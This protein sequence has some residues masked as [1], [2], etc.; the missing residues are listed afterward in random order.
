MLRTKFK[1]VLICSIVALMFSILLYVGCFILQSLS[2]LFFIYIPG[3][4]GFI[5]GF[6]TSILVHPRRWIWLPGL[7]PAVSVNIGYQVGLLFYNWFS[8]EEVYLH[9]KMLVLILW[10][11]IPI[12]LASIVGAFL[13][14]LLAHIWHKK[15]KA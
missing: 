8:H 2:T 10:S 7:L 14:Q 11:G 12:L 3:F 15:Q 1:T 13:G 4:I 5:G 6:V 9:Y